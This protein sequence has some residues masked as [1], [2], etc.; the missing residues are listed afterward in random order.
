MGLRTLPPGP[1]LEPDGHRAWQLAH[2]AELLA[3]D[4][5]GCVLPASGDAAKAGVARLVELV[6][7]ELEATVPGHSPTWAAEA[8]A[9]DDPIVAC[10]LAT[11]EDWCVMVR[12]DTWRL[13]AACL[14]FPSRWVLA[15]KVGGTIAEIHEPVPRYADELGGLVERFFDRLDSEKVVW[16]TNWNLWD[17]PRLS[18]A[19]READTPEYDLPDTSQV[20][21]KVFLRVER[22][23]LR[24]LT[25]DAIAFSIRVHQRRLAD[26]V[27][28]QGALEL[29]RST[30]AGP[31]VVQKKL[32]RLGEPVRAWLATLDQAGSTASP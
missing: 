27:R 24:R 13:R 16:R 22:Q 26:V 32:G 6:D 20:G 31:D 25:P 5:A 29:L 10:G 18:Q 8:I 23:T 2:K 28:Q 17:D 3:A 19:F 9:A 30:V 15:E 21:D 4:R 14:C 7:A 11:Q 1:W 12:E